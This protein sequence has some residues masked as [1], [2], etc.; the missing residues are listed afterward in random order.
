MHKYSENCPFCKISGIDMFELTPEEKIE[1]EEIDRELVKEIDER[2]DK[3]RKL[4]K[5]N[6]EILKK[7][8]EILLTQGIALTAENKTDHKI[9]SIYSFSI[10]LK[11]P[12]A[13][14][15]SY[16]RRIYNVAHY[17]EIK[18]EFLD[19]LNFKMLD[20]YEYLDTKAR[21]Q[22]RHAEMINVSFLK[23]CRKLGEFLKRF[24]K[25]KQDTRYKIYEVHILDTRLGMVKE[26]VSFV[27][28]IEKILEKIKQDKKQNA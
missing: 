15:I 12:F 25:T 23:T 7:Q 6:Q 22:C 24:F 8:K 26:Y 5:E 16:F 10:D 9:N 21:S 14:E 13:I 3:S 1:L 11:S 28:Q 17:D 18:R 20:E 19:K 27:E 2:K 4:R